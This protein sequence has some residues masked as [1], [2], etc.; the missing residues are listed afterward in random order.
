MPFTYEVFVAMVGVANYVNVGFNKLLDILCYR[1][2]TGRDT[3]FLRKASISVIVTGCSSSAHSSKNCLMYRILLFF[4]VLLFIDYHLG[5]ISFMVIYGGYICQ[6]LT[7]VEIQYVTTL[8]MTS[9]IWFEGTYKRSRYHGNEGLCI[10]ASIPCRL[11]ESVYP[12]I[13]QD[14]NKAHKNHYTSMVPVCQ[15]FLYVASARTS[16]FKICAV[17]LKSLLHPRCIGR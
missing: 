3:S 17:S 2:A 6:I 4:S 11:R 12:E 9:L 14:N 10:I 13:Q 5:L 7:S 8:P 15:L 1:F 16:P